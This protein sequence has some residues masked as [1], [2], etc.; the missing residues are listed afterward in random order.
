MDPTKPLINIGI[1]GAGEHMTRG[2]LEHLARDPR[3]RIAAWHDPKKDAAHGAALLESVGASWLTEEEILA[4]PGI[5]MVF[6]GSPDRFHIPALLACIAAGKHVMCEK[7]I[8]VNRLDM[9]DLREAIDGSAKAGLVLSTCHPRRFDPPILDLKRMLESPNEGDHPLRII[10]GEIERFEFGFWYH[11]PSKGDLHVSLLSDHFSHEIDLLRF[12]F[13]VGFDTFSGQVVHDSERS[14]RAR[15]TAS[16]KKHLNFE[17]CGHRHLEEA[18]ED[19]VFVEIVR[20]IGTRGSA[21]LHLNTGVLTEERTGK[22]IPLRPK[23]YETMFRDLN[24]NL[25]D[26]AL[27]KETPYIGTENI[28]FNNM[29]A[30]A[31]VDCGSFRILD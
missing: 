5:G 24:K 27:G 28:L 1:I 4:N 22:T 7:P 30:A 19:K 31:L 9:N 11:A 14:Y 17:F 6:V 3:V 15:G 18:G 10:V 25:I 23:S 29:S 20:L 21:S 8:G 26:A 2:H 12:M 13:G 16:G